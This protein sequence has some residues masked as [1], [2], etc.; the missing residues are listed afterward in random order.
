MN[1][2]KQQANKTPLFSWSGSN[3]RLQVLLRAR[4]DAKQSITNKQ[5]K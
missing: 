4:Q 1:N 2:T 5:T 3:K